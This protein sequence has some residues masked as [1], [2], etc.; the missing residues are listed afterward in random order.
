MPKVSV[1][2]P[3]YNTEKYLREC[4]DSVVNQTLKDIEIICIN[5]GSTDNSLEIL[6]EYAKNDTRIKIID[7]QN[8][9]YGHSMNVGLDN[10]QGEY[11]GIVE[12]DDYVELNMYEALY[13][14]A[15]ETNV[16][17]IK[18]DH[19]RFYEDMVQ[20]YNRYCSDMLYYDRILNPIK[21]KH[22]FLCRACIWSGIY[23]ADFL[24]SK[25]IRFN[26]TPGARYQDQGFY[27][28]TTMSAD[29]VYII[30]QAF[31]HYRFFQTNSTNHPD[32]F[33]WNK[34]ESDYIMDIINAVPIWK[35]NFVSLLWHSKF[36][37]YTFQYRKLDKKRKKERLQVFRN[38]F[39]TALKNQEMDKSF[40]TVR[41]TELFDI[42]IKNPNKFYRIM[43]NSDSFTEKIFSVKNTRSGCKSYKVLRFCGIK[44]KFRNKK[45]EREIAAK[46]QRD[47]LYCIK[48]QN[49]KIL[50]H[51]EEKYHA[52]Q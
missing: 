12:P 33:D 38:E 41:E 51:L 42:L 43:T 34:A 19:W 30:N 48:A 8:T 20:R 44:F 7:K 40:F 5:D 29:S 36:C 9:G 50:K 39:K 46:E 31:Y 32:G 52:V 47:M 21:D 18:A 22:I 37:T 11:V 2:I 14:K 27:W 45:K 4:L 15:K 49:E 35:Q 3:V 26:E 10:A 25:G 6:K 23:S 1:V 24:R 17:F 13:S 16:D 28:L